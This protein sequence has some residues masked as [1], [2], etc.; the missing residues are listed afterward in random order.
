MKQLYRTVAAS[1]GVLMTTF[2]VSAQATE[3][4]VKLKVEGQTIVATMVT[5]GDVAKPP[6]VLM[7]HGF[8]GSRNE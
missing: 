7:L 4:I 2:L 8:T 1:L 6:V 3:T 5:P